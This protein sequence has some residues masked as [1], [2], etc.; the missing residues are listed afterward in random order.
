MP[1]DR[2]RSVRSQFD[3]QA[4]WYTV[5]QVHRHSEGLD[6][7]LH[8]AAPATSDFALDVATGTGFT[9]L[10]L[11]PHCRRVVGLDMT[12]GMLREAR[13][14]R[15][16]P[17]AANLEFC[18]GD[19]EAHAVPRRRVRSRDV[20][21]RRPPLSARRAGRRGD[22]ARRPLGR[23]SRLRRHMRARGRAPRRADERLGST[24]RSIA[25]V[26]RS[27]EPSPCAVR[28]P[29]TAY[30]RAAMTHVPL[31]F[32]DWVR[33]AG[34]PTRNRGGAAGG[35]PGRGARGR[36]RVPDPAGRDGRAVR[37]GRTR[38]AGR[39]TV[40]T[41]RDAPSGAPRRMCLAARA[42]LR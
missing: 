13:A 20:P 31:T 23:P 32:D 11:A 17:G 27:S 8:L 9:A 12:A 35:V 19:A 3:R 5:S 28:G 25:R 15:S 40:T 2:K 39:K 37:L 16:D 29:R 18:L 38:A 33:R 14:L 36:G 1:D 21:P 24:A 26:L 41:R 34:V 6:V 7:L 4:A 10:A 30:R 42:A 22:G